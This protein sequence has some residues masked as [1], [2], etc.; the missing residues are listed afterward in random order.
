MKRFKFFTY[1]TALL[2]VLYCSGQHTIFETVV[3]TLALVSGLG[4]NPTAILGACSELTAFR[5]A[6]ESLDQEITRSTRLGRPMFFRNMFPK[7]TFVQNQGTTRSTFT[8]KPSEPADDQSLWTN[9]TVSGGITVPGCS[10]TYEDIGVDFFERTYGPKRRDFRGP[11][12]CREH[13]QFQHAIDDFIEGYVDELGQVM[14]RTWEFGIRGDVMR[15]GDWFVDG[16]KTTGPNAVLTAGRAYQGLSQDLLDD[17]AVDLINTGA[18]PN[19][20]GGYVFEGD[21]GPIYPLYIDM[22]DSANILKANSTIRDD[23]RFASMGKDADGVFSLWKAI[24][25]SR[26]IGNFRHITTNIAP[27]FNFTGGVYVPVSPFKDI[28]QIGTDQETLTDAYK[29]AG[30]A[31]AMVPLPEGMTIEVVKPQRAGLDFEAANYN[32]EWDFITGGE[33]ICNPAVYDPRHEKG[34][35]FAA[36]AYA[37]RPKRIHSMKT[38]IYKR[39]APSRS[40]IY[41]S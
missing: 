38:I 8:I 23:A 20:N 34:R 16:T 41:C 22:R 7:S 11:I 33:R 1:A 40:S 31:G 26:I 35:H 12:I 30:F 15:L 29:N 37:A 18:S 17:M 4:V 27:R 32:G 14:A 19:G 9:I 24:G 28:T 39:C 3:G 2:A 21:A 13:L 5:I 6:T 36:I 25:A 10:P